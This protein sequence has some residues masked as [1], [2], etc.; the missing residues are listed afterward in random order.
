MILVDSSI[1]I[2]H[3]RDR[4][5]TLASF[6][7]RERVLVHPFV[8]GEV[9]LGNLLQREKILSQLEKLPV[10]RLTSVEEVARMIERQHLYGLG[11]G[12]VDVCLLASTLFTPNAL[13]WTRDKRLYSAASQF[14]VSADLD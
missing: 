14:G 7:A 5:D 12:Y 6:P 11:L 2:D 1:W 9:A 10:A 13:L 4:D 3:L 8:I